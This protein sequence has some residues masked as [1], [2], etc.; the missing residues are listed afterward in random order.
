MYCGGA[1]H[2]CPIPPPYPQTRTHIS[3]DLLQHAF[4]HQNH[5]C[6][7]PLGHGYVCPSQQIFRPR[8]LTQLNSSEAHPRSSSF[9]GRSFTRQ[10]QLRTRNCK[11]QPC[12]RS[13]HPQPHRQRAPSPS[14]RT[15]FNVQHRQARPEKGEAHLHSQSQ[16]PHRVDSLSRAL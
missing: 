16:L 10:L 11:E 7:P 5:C 13:S 6:F 14:Y 4:L 2:S 9:Q 3:T 12:Y 8:P 1:T 15:A